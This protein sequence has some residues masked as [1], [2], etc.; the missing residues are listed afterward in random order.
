MK[1]RKLAR[2]LPLML[3]AL[4]AFA[5]SESVASVSVEVD[6]PVAQA[7]SILQD[8]SQAHNYVPNL[9]KTEIVSA[10]KN[11]V[12]AHRRVYDMDG[13][14]LEET[15]SEWQEGVGFIIHIHEGD[16][17]MAPFSEISF[18]YHIEAAREDATAIA[19]SMRFVMP[20]GS[21]GTAMGD[22][23][24]V[25]IVEDNLVQVAAGMKHYYEMG[26][27][28]SDADRERLAGQVTVTTPER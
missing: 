3:I 4:P 5:R 20:L 24:I 25:P 27:P 2:L 9:S 11:G 1:F 7:W 22:W 17:P 23:F 19:L 16:E 10:Q 21:V 14:Y 18:R 26:T 6:V 8:F 15:I 13:D 28:A 12:G